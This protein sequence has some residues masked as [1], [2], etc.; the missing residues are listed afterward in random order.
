M[1][2]IIRNCRSKHIKT[3]WRKRVGWSWQCVRIAVLAAL[4]LV[5]CSCDIDSMYSTRYRVLF[6][7][8]NLPNY[9]KLS[10]VID[11]PGVYA[12]LRYKQVGGKQFVEVTSPT[13]SYLFTDAITSQAFLGLGG[14]IFGTNYNLELMAFDLACPICEQSSI[15]LSYGDDGIASCRHCGSSFNLNNYGAI[16]KVGAKV[17]GT[18]RGLLRYRPIYFGTLLQIVNK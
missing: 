12:Q 13:G 6:V 10:C 16:E 17:Q 5:P 4:F 9:D 2:S 8:D 14:L 15:R 7:L 1:L 11:N 3:D 18:V